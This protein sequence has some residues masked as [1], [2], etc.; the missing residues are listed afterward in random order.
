MKI[1]IIYKNCAINLYGAINRIRLIEKLF[2]KVCKKEAQLCLPHQK[3]VSA[4]KL[5]WIQKFKN[6][7]HK[8]NN[9]ATVKY[10]FINHIKCYG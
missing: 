3:L 9:I 2:I 1:S 8:R 4:M 10:P 6:G 5:T 7:K